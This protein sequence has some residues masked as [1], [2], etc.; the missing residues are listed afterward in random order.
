[1]KKIENMG[2]ENLITVLD[3][4]NPRGSFKMADENTIAVKGIAP[5]YVKYPEGYY[6]NPKN[7][8]TNKHNTASGM[9]EAFEVVVQK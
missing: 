6:Y 3:Q 9:Y 2:I 4:M 1:M 7:G 8:I 5:Q